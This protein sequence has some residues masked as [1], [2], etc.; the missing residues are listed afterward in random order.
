MG[1]LGGIAKLLVAIVVVAAAATG[2]DVVD[3][4]ELADSA[5]VRAQSY[6]NDV[7]LEG[8]ETALFDHSTDGE[9]REAAPEFA[10][11]SDKTVP[12]GLAFDGAEVDGEIPA[13]VDSAATDGAVAE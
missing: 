10:R 7:E 8:D 12:S 9:V 5:T 3:V 11:P 2:A 6:F 13:D 1:G 4:V